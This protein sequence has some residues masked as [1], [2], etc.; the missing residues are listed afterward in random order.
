MRVWGGID[1]GNSGALVFITESR[2]IYFF[3][4]PT[5]QVKSGKKTTTRL[6]PSEMANMLRIYEKDGH[7]LSM[8]HDVRIFI[9]QVQA[10]PDQGRTSIFNFGMGYGY[11]IMACSAFQIPYELI[12]P[13]AWK[14]EMMAGM[15]KEKDASCVKAMQL[16]PQCS[17]QLRRPKRG[18]PG[19]WIYLDGRG[20]ALLLAEYNR[21]QG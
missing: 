8:S 5:A 21:R 14:K 18:K 19:E 16:F 3:D 4:A 12:T 13:Q 20:D 9:E 10:M 2:N 7:R 17:D 15:G 6:I 1:P 11:W